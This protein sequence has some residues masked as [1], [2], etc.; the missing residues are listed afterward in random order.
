GGRG[1]AGRCRRGAARRQLVR[2]GRR[3]GGGAAPTAGAVRPHPDGEALRLRPGPGARR[4]RRA[5][6]PQGRPRRAGGRGPV[7]VT[8][9]G[10]L[11]ER[12]LPDGEVA[13]MVTKKALSRRTSLRG[14]GT[15]VA[16]PLLDA[17]VP[18]LSA[19]AGT[20]AA[21]ERLRRLG[22]VYVP[23]GCDGKRWAPP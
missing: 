8:D 10:N 4:D 16:L 11:H 5:G 2:G 17:M 9:P 15:A 13:T 3:S 19:Q 22:Y 23:M 7:L 14:A 20:P 1:P 21:P 12:P 18:S 6:R